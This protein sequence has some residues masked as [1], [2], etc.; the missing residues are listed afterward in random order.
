MVN[1]LR[2][3][4]QLR[5]NKITFRANNCFISFIKHCL[6]KEYPQVFEKFYGSGEKKSAKAFTFA[7]YLPGAKPQGEV[8][9]LT[10]NMC[11]LVLSS[12]NTALLIEL[13]SCLMKNRDKPYPLP[14]NNSMTLV[15]VGFELLEEIREDKVIIKLLSPLIVRHH[16]RDTN[17]DIYL[18]YTS[19]DF[20]EKLN[21]TVKN[22]IGEKG[23]V[24]LK[25]I[26]AGRTVAQCLESKVNCS[27][28]IFELSGEPET[29]NRLYKEGLG[30][31]TGCGYGCFTVLKQGDMA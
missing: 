30:S 27:Y 29:L 4:F 15:S 8:F 5:E 6:S 7:A 12:S 23:A 20:L 14:F 9:A 24:S 21:V 19:P 10:E 22:R 16:D 26:K 11:Y 3:G 17:K 1:R 25:P 2:L 31:R 18:D 28:G 13:N